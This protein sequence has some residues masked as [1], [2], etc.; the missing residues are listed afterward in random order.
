MAYGNLTGYEP[1]AQPGAYNFQTGD[2]KKLLMFGPEA[3][4]LKAR[5]DASASVAP[6]KTAGLGNYVGQ[7][8]VDAAGGGPAAPP[9]SVADVG[10]N[11]S[12]APTEPAMSPNV[13]APA[14]EQNGWGGSDTGVNETGTPQPEMP[15]TGPDGGPLAGF[16]SRG[17][18]IFEGPDGR[19]YEYNA[20]RAGSKGG[21][22]DTSKSVSGAFDPNKDCTHGRRERRRS[23]CCSREGICGTAIG[24]PSERSG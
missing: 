10:P 5:L 14:P 11:M 24:A 21:W 1:A 2:G 23:S 18:G 8:L 20:P 9:Q 17:L 4:A 12:M 3:E 13:P 16:K 7:S 15:T 19:L 6:Q 22:R